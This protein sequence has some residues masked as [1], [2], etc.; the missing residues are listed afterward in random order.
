MTRPLLLLLVSWLLTA[1]S[2]PAPET[3]TMPCL[4][5]AGDDDPA[6]MKES[7]L[8]RVCVPP[9]RV[10][11]WGAAGFVVTPVD[12]SQLAARE[13]L[14][15]PGILGNAR[16]GSATRSPFVVANGWRFARNPAGRYAYVLPAGKAALAAA[17]AA[18]YGADA[19]LTIDAAD[20]ASLGRMHAFLRDVPPVSLPPIADIGVVDDGSPLTGEALNLLA[21]RNLLFQIV[22]APSPRFAV[23]VQLGTKEYPVEDAADPS[24]F[25]LKVRRQLSDE[26]RTLR[27][28]GSEVVVARLT[29][30][31]DRVR[32]HLLNYGGREILGL[33]IR[34]RG[35]YK[36]KAASAFDVGHTQLGDVLV[37][38]GATEF[39]IPRM[40]TYA[41]V[42]LTTGS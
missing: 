12:E 41:V 8:V 1:Q 17:E 14:P 18:A 7:G 22:Q 13:A 30:D 34:L 29:G 15:A 25:A 10:E 23:N 4:Y 20:V 31:A 40:T 2:A 19:L 36:E 5:S 3:P 26:K 32:L 38:D 39:S 42:D 11:V 35:L 24:A 9:A 37:A 16:R 21:R 6:V 27:V 33:R 28:Y